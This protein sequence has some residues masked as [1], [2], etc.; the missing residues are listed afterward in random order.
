MLRIRPMIFCNIDAPVPAA[1][2][3][4]PV[5]QWVSTHR[6]CSEA[7]L[8]RC[9]CAQLAVQ[10]PFIIFMSSM[11]CQ[12]F[13]MVSNIS[14]VPCIVSISESPI[15]W[16]YN[17]VTST[18]FKCE[19]KPRLY[20]GRMVMW[21]VTQDAQITFSVARLEYQLHLHR[22]GREF[23]SLCMQEPK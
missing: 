14:I 6:C 8:I 15:L 16:H 4:S 23:N 3:R 7:N 20:W 19:T 11:F 10:K 5:Q 13:L 9:C 21:R 22:L 1:L 18:L 12:F 17:W 2:S